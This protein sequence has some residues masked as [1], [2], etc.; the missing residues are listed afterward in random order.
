MLFRIK[1]VVKGL[2]CQNQLDN[3]IDSYHTVINSNYLPST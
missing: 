3:I 1:R 2:D